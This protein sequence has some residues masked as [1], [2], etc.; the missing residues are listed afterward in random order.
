MSDITIVLGN[1]NYSSWSMRGWLLLQLAGATHEEIVI[2]L[3]EDDTARRIGEH[4]PSGRV[5]VLK[6][7]DVRV[8]DS[9][10][11]AEHLNERFP[12][13]GL[14]PDAPLARATARSLAAEMHS[15][16]QALRQELPMNMRG[17]G[18]YRDVRVSEAAQGD[19]DRICGIWRACRR[20]FGREGDFLFGAPT[21]ADAF[22]AP[23]VSRF[24]TYAVPLDKVC[25]AYRET[26]MAWQPVVRWTEAALAEPWQNDRYER[27]K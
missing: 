10:A 12:E 14:W 26:V 18:A 22:F 9:L 8:W 5:P 23:V 7:G 4:S 27:P 3:G 20:D 25:A 16:F 24:V 21:A 17:A 13:A 19:I 2:P 6:D 11:I 15:S 1:K